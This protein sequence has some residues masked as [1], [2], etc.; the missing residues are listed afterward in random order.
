MKNL[1]ILLLLCSFVLTSEVFCGPMIRLGNLNV[2]DAPVG[3]ADVFLT[4]LP[5]QIEQG[6]QD[7]YEAI[8]DIEQLKAIADSIS[9]IKVKTSKGTFYNDFDVCKKESTWCALQSS[10]DL[11]GWFQAQGPIL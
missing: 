2:P 1:N 3:R 10:G 9:Y 8:Q 5:S 6:L 4:K 11:K 7:R